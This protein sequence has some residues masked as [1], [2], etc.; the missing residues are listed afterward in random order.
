[1]PA[2]YLFS[3]FTLQICYD[4]FNYDA[5]LLAYHITER[6]P[7]DPYDTVLMTF[8]ND[9]GNHLLNDTSVPR[10][11]PT[12]SMRAPSLDSPQTF[13]IM[14]GR[15]G[16]MSTDENTVVCRWSSSASSYSHKVEVRETSVGKY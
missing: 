7:P 14:I 12:H 13:T 8:I 11:L 3:K 5:D 15:D 2:K 1:M 6:M 4:A 16:V 10:L 9:A